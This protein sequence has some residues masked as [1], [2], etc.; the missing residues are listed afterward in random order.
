MKHKWF[1]HFC[2]LEAWQQQSSE[3]V[4]LKHKLET[5]NMIIA[6]HV[7]R[8]ANADLL[9]KD[10]YV[11]NSHLAASIQRLEQQRSRANL[12]HQH[13]QGLSGVPGLP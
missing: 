13:H 6:E 4:D 12:L 10:L 3:I 9:V 11:E 2:L 1:L 5:Q 7:Q 8:L